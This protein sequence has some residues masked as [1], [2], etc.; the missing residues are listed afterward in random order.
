M[1]SWLVTTST[2]EPD[3][4]FTT[5]TW[6]FGMAALVAS[7]TRPVRA[8]VPTCA[9]AHQAVVKKA[10][11]TTGKLVEINR[12]IP[13]RDYRDCITAVKQKLTEAHQRSLNWGV[14]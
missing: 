12:L 13:Y 11:A 7:T 10:V 2:A 6:T 3:S 9:A 8:P 4:S 5:L 1:P 14:N